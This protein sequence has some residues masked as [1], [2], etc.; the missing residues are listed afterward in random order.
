MERETN[1][2]PVTRIVTESDGTSAFV[3]DALLVTDAGA[4]GLLGDPVP[5]RDI[6]L[7]VNPPDYDYDWHCAPSRQFI[8]MLTGEIEI[9]VG[10][11]E[12]RRF[13]P[14]DVVFVEDTEGKGHRARNTGM[15]WRT[16]AFVRVTGDVPF[17]GS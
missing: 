7:R 1:T 11:G 13:S 16:S 10:T 14:G 8:L 12:Q 6:I 17:L 2:F 15:T 9:E 4:I 5:T 3:D